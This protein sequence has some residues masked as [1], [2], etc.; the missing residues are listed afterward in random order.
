MT[1]KMCPDTAQ[2]PLAKAVRGRARSPPAENHWLRRLRTVLSL[3]FYFSIWNIEYVV[4]KYPST[5]WLDGR[6]LAC[7][8]LPSPHHT[9]AWGTSQAF[10]PHPWGQA[11][12]SPIGGPAPALTLPHVPQVPTPWWSCL[13]QH[14][15]IPH[16]LGSKPSDFSDEMFFF[17]LKKQQQQSI[18][19]GLPVIPGPYKQAS[20]SRI[21]RK[22]SHKKLTLK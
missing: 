9:G 10:T 3:R 15:T 8:L 7:S 18:I 19:I 4:G 21:S 12:A 1:P 22:I 20:S 13:T 6:N 2:W 17:S 11:G 5:R 16:D 14:L